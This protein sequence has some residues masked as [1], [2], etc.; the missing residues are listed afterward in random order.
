MLIPN[1][2][3]RVEDHVA[4]TMS[5]IRSLGRQSATN[6]NVAIVA[7]FAILELA[8]YAIDRCRVMDK[9]WQIF[10]DEASIELCR[11]ASGG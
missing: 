4:Q 5:S 11:L 7:H 3:P 1:L 2:S 9:W 6:E 8:K 10:R